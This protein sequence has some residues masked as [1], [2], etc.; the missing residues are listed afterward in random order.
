MLRKENMLRKCLVDVMTSDYPSICFNYNFL[1]TTKK[2]T[3][4]KKNIIKSVPGS[5]IKAILPTEVVPNSH[6]LGWIK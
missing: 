1:E 3:L 5:V 2:R 4:S 6:E